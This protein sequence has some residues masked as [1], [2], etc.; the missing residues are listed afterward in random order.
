MAILV[1]FPE[2]QVILIA[3]KDKGLVDTGFA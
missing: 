3:V 2:K 1:N